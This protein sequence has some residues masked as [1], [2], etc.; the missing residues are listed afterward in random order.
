MKNK[1]GVIKPSDAKSNNQVKIKST[2]KKGRP[3]V[4]SKEIISI[5]E[6]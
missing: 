5:N 1:H 4:K 2:G 3:L 6:E